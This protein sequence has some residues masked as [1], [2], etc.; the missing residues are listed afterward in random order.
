MLDMCYKLLKGIVFLQ[1][2]G[3]DLRRLNAGNVV[4]HV[5]PG[6]CILHILGQSSA[7]EGHIEI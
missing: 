1:D 4:I 6:C 7:G 3:V 5:V 2:T